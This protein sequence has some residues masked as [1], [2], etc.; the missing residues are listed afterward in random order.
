[1]KTNNSKNLNFRKFAIALISILVLAFAGFHLA[2]NEDFMGKA[3]LAVQGYSVINLDSEHIDEFK[4][5]TEQAKIEYPS[6]RYAH[7]DE[8]CTCKVNGFSGCEAYISNRGFCDS[9]YLPDGIYCSKDSNLNKQSYVW[10]YYQ[11]S[12]CSKKPFKMSKCQN[13]CE[14]GTCIQDICTETD[15]GYDVFTKGK[16]I[17]HNALKVSASG[18]DSCTSPDYL[19]EYFCDGKILSF[20]IDKCEYG[21][22]LGKCQTISCADTDKGKD[23]FTKGVVKGGVL[24]GTYSIGQRYDACKDVNTVTE[25]FCTQSGTIGLT[26]IRC[27][28]GCRSGACIS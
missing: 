9:G 26:D 20:K 6:P 21:C 8:Y 3:I 23:E 7:Q 28:N 16:T 1:M 17:G 15:K 14:E 22:T 12:D 19:K 24:V 13:G 11:F 25:Y 2:T 10:H 4:L 27:E 18:D 5:C